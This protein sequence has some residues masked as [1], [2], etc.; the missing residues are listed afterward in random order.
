MPPHS[1]AVEELAA[2]LGSHLDTG[3]SD[4]Q[5][6]QIR[7]QQGPN[8]LQEAPPVP[9]WLRFLGQFKD[10]V[11]WILIVAAVVAGLTGEV[12]DTIAILAIVLLNG[13]IGFIQEER[14]EQALASLKKL[15]APLAKAIR[16]GKLVSLPARDLVP[17]DRIELEAGDNVPADVRLI[18]SSSLRIQEAALTGESAPV[19]KEASALLPADTSLG[20][21]QNMA[22]MGTVVAAGK[23]SAIVAATAMQAEL[24]KIAGLIARQQR[25]PTPLQRRLAELGKLLVIV[26]LVLVAIVFALQL[27]RGGNLLEVFLVSVSLAVAAVPEGLPA[28]VTLTLALGLQRMVARNALVRKLPSVETLGSVTVI[29]TDKTGTLTRNEMTVRS[30][31]VGTREFKVTGTGYQPRGE[32][33]PQSDDANDAGNDPDLHLLLTIAA[34]CNNAKLMP[35]GEKNEQ[36]QVI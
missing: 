22:Y 18:K 10:L 35:P 28:V 4:E 26:C 27:S 23:A 2:A 5:A 34:Y 3:L 12:A 31:V 14:A 7:A 30:I 15:S 20:D 9:A 16:S 24:G 25:E 32:L 6:S 1:L 33:Q 13:V 29:C 19:E 21:R 8:E 11:I 17:G 36:W